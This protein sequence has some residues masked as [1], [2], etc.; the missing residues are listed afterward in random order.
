MVDDSAIVESA[1][2]ALAR[3]DINTFLGA[4]D[5]EVEWCLPEHHPLWPGKALLGPQAVLEGHLARVP[6]VYDDFRI[7]LQRIVALGGR[8][9]VET[10]GR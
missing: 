5:D 2:E 7:D 4:L 3:G 9:G 1:Y 8:C 6:E 10:R